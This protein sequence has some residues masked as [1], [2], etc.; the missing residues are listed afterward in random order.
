MINFARKGQASTHELWLVLAPITEPSS[1]PAIND[2]DTEPDWHRESSSS[3]SG[4]VAESTATL[5]AIYKRL[6]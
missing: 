3:D 5:T 2:T 1:E 4:A 6:S